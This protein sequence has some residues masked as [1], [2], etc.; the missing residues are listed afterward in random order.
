MAKKKLT[1]AEAMAEL[2]V[3]LA[4]LRSD[5][6]SVDDLA[7]SVA[8]ATELIAECRAILTTTEEEVEKLVNSEA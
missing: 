2:E 1:Y 6:L 7:K 5:E 3:I 8:R 4:R